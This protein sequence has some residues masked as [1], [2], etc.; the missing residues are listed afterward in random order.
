MFDNY[1]A[2]IE[3]VRA[4]KS[5][6]L[7]KASKDPEF[8]DTAARFAFSSQMLN[9]L[10]HLNIENEYVERTLKKSLERDKTYYS[11]ALKDIINELDLL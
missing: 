8:Q 4:A 2:A 5:D 1:E 9:N 7:E 10:P 11:E 3:S 6:Y